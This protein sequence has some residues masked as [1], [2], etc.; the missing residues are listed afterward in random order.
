MAAGLFDLSPL[1][2]VYRIHGGEP[3]AAPEW[4]VVVYDE[5]FMNVNAV[6]NGPDS[7]F[8][9]NRLFLGLNRQFTEHFNMDLGYQ[10][11]TLN[12]C[13]PELINQLPYHPSCNSLSICCIPAFTK[14]ASKIRLLRNAQFE[15]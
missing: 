11:Q 14:S 4:A 15:S 10:M 9:Q 6:G 13:Q 1:I 2:F 12:N 8:D 7:G 5:I 3:P